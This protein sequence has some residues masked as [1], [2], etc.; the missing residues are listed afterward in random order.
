MPMPTT[1]N[2]TAVRLASI[3]TSTRM[4]PALRGPISRSLGQRRSTVQ[5]GDGANG[6]G[7]GKSGGQRQQRQA[8]GGNL[9][10]Q[11]H[12]HVEPLAGG[13]VPGVIAASAA[14]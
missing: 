8:S 13:R 14:G 12:A 11:Q 1:A 6:L 9:R 10:A 4:P 7:G 5:A 3:S 2:A